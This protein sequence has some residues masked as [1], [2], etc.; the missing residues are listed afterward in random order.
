MYA[1]HCG[2]PALWDSRIRP[3]NVKLLRGVCSTSVSNAERF[4][5]KLRPRALAFLPCISATALQRVGVQWELII[6]LGSGTLFW[7][8]GSGS[9]ENM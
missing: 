8:L 4:F 3:I 7:V 9:F 5:D 6:A 1:D 2:P